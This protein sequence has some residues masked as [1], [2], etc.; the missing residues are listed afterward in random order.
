MPVSLEYL[1]MR[2][3]S[4]GETVRLNGDWKSGKDGRGSLTGEIGWGEAL[5]M[6]LALK[7]AQLPVTVEPYAVLEVAP[8]LTITMQGERPSIAG[9]VLVPTGE[10]T[11][12]ELPPSTVQVSDDTVKIGRA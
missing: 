7:G 4:A 3:T 5:S 8:D 6:N 1:Q 11:V 10:I 12:R 2:A 9:K